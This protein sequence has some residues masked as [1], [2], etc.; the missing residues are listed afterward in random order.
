M[1]EIVAIMRPGEGER[2]AAR[3]GAIGLDAAMATDLST[4]ST[5]RLHDGDGNKGEVVA[6]G[7]GFRLMSA[8]VGLAR[9][10]KFG[11]AV[12]SRLAADGLVRRQ[13]EGRERAAVGDDQQVCRRLPRRSTR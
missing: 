4:R 10:L 2:I 13:R 6:I 8:I 11:G 9:K 5:R 7:Q 1:R 3:K 12:H